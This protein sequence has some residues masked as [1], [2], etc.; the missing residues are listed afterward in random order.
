MAD[1]YIDRTYVREHLGQGYEAAI[2]T[3]DGVDIVT[4]IEAATAL[5]QGAMRAAGYAT[6]ATTTDELVKLAVL[7]GVWAMLASTPEANVPLPENWESHPANIAY[8]GILA[9]TLQLSADPSKI[10]AKGGWKMSS[11]AA[12]GSDTSYVQRASRSQLKGY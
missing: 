2:S 7:E 8:L 11:H 4:K 9:G 1:A 12:D 6:A 5:L 3:L 10:A